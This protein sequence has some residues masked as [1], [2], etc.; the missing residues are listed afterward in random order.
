MVPLFPSLVAMAIMA[1]TASAR[2][3]DCRWEGDTVDPFT[4]KDGR[5][6]TAQMRLS[7]GRPDYARLHIHHAV[8]GMVR[9]DILFDEIG[10]TDRMVDG[11]ISYLMDDGKVI[12]IPFIEAK[13]PTKHAALSPLT[14]YQPSPFTRH[15]A[16]GQLPADDALELAQ[17]ER[18]TL[19]RHSLLSTG[20]ITRELQKRQSDG[21]RRAMACVTSE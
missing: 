11:A 1:T 17:A 10:D 13:P 16:T 19:L 4:G 9:F 20:A 3:P 8:D 7:E 5:Y 12:T 6:L 14:P 21:L 15:T 2:T 18:I